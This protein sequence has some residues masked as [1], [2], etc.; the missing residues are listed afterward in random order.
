MNVSR[1]S[2][3]YSEFIGELSDSYFVTVVAPRNNKMDTLGY[4]VEGGI[5]VIRIPEFFFLNKNPILKAIKQLVS[6]L[7][8]IFFI[9]FYLKNEKFDWVVMPTPTIT[10]SPVVK[11]IKKKY[12]CKFYLILRDIF[13]Q[14]AVDMGFLKKESFIWRFYRYLESMTYEIADIIGCM[15]PENINFLNINNDISPSKLKLLENWTSCKNLRNKKINSYRKTFNVM[16]GGNLGVPQN[17]PFLIKVAEKIQNHKDIHFH[18][19][20]TGTEEEKIRKMIHSSRLCNISLSS[21]LS[22]NEYSKVLVNCD[23]G[24]VLLDEKF[25]VPNIPSRM[26]AYWAAGVPVLAATDINTD[27]NENFI[28]KY[29]GGDW[30]KM[31]DYDAFIDKIMVFKNDPI[32]C[33]ELGLNGKN[34]VKE[35]FL[36]E[37]AVKKFST[38]ISIFN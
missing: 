38:Q 34:A 4:A 21:R 5:G 13:P 17:V 23:L 18:I 37:M 3:L 30:V 19:I 32:I 12:K 22:R 28:S 31:N 8:F 11:W 7:L 2:G 27:I 25:T 1:D 14:N 33:H 20:G 16:F 15:S 9:T 6:P 36:A 29:N 26:L 35:N 10:L 24:I